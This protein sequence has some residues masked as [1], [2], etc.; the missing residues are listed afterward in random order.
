MRRSIPERPV[1]ATETVSYSLAIVAGLAVAAAAAWAVLKELVF[2]PDELTVFDL[3]LTAC[4]AHPVVGVRLGSPLSGYGVE[5]ANRHA[6]QRVRHKTTTVDGVR[7]VTV[8]FQLRGPRG[9][10]TVLATATRDR[11]A[12][13]GWAFKDIVV[14]DG[15]GQ[16]PIYVKD[17]AREAAIQAQ[18]QAAAAS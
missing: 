17:A 10:A 13:G 4:R 11:A 9:V 5:S 14:T 8:Q 7:T 15:A 12:P 2:Q 6:R 16:R 3:A 1:T 18:A